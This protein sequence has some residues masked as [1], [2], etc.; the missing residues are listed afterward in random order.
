[1][2]FRGDDDVPADRPASM[3]HGIP[4]CLKGSEKP[5]QNQSYT[6]VLTDT[7]VQYLRFFFC[8]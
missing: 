3:I 7:F 4:S 6:K 2:F 5:F 8:D 1:M